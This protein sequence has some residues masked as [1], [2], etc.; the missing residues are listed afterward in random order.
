MN[1]N[2]IVTRFAPSPT[3][4]LHIG[5]IRTALYSWL[6]SK[7]NNGKFI[8]RIEDTDFNNSKNIYSDHIIYILKWLGL[9]WDEGPYYQS[10]RIDIYKDIINYMLINN[11]AYKCYC[12]QKRLINLRNLYNKQN[13]KFKY[14]RYCRN[15]IKYNIENINKYVVRFK[16]PLYGQVNFKDLLYGNISINN[17][18]LDDFI[19]QR[20]NGVPTYNFCVV[21]DDYFM[22]ITHVIRG[23]DH[24]NNTFKQINIIKSL[25]FNIPKYIHLP[26]IL[27]NYGNKLSKK[28]SF[29]NIN[30]YIENGFIPDSILNYLL[31]LG[32][33]YKNYEII[34]FNEM[35]YLFDLKKLNKSPCRLNINKMLW[36]N[37]YYLSYISYNK[38]IKYFNNYIILNKI[39]LDKIKNIS[40]IISFILPRSYLIKD[41]VDFCLIFNKKICLNILL[42]KKYKNKFSLLILKKIYHFFLKLKK[43]NYN[44]IILCLN[45]LFNKFNFLKKKYIYIILHIFITG[46]I[47]SPNISIIILYLKKKKFLLRIR[48]SL[49]FLNYLK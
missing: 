33:S 3:G 22:S 26:M 29:L 7:K 19:I 31:R 23:E 34:H 38:F 35:K 6:Y 44:N 2:N 24:I 11:L 45:L 12:S 4:Y 13:I 21:V 9:Y 40:E 43:W 36:L 47:K 16:S 8:L 1:N 28:N 10:K 42:I 41:V 25:N 37:K 15:R 49:F 46:K 39:Y 14:D 17:N 20:S 32:W 48:Y 27:D 18:Q 5:N 30:S